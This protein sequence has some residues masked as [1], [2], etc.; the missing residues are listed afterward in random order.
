MLSKILFTTTLLLAIYMIGIDFF[1]S[2]YTSQHQWQDNIVKAQNYLYNKKNSENVIIGS[3]LSN[4]L[5]MDSI[6]NLTN[7]AFSGLSIF[8]G[9]NLVLHKDILP[10]NVFIEMNVA[11]RP[12]DDQ[13]ETSLFSPISFYS[14]KIFSSLRDDKQPVGIAGVYVNQKLTK[15]VLFKIKSF[16]GSMKASKVNSNKDL[17]QTMLNN[18]I[19]QY[20]ISP[21]TILIEDRFTLLQKTIKY[22]ESKGT[23]I[24]FFE[25]PVNQSLCNLPKA[26][27]IRQN[28]Q[29]YFPNKNYTYIST[30]SCSEYKTTD[31]VH[32]TNKEAI[33]YTL[34][35]RS[36]AE[37]II[38]QKNL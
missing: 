38:R 36:E 29:K 3:S 31:G 22:L 28:F 24:T 26:T 13:F 34:Y 14:K 19:T 11:L 5:I 10:K 32:L 37:N 25:M 8:D 35:F 16:T 21:D 7:I 20:S 18:Q 15:K 6:P 17:F 33:K 1:K 30:P 9:L 2:F 4:R 27:I 12:K 23:K